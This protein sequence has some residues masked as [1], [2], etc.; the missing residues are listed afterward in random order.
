MRLRW[1]SVVTVLLLAACAPG[2]EE[3]AAPSVRTQPQPVLEPVETDAEDRSKRRARRFA[4]G[5]HGITTK[6]PKL[7]VYNRPQ[8]LSPWHKLDTTNP[9]DQ[10]L[11]LLVTEARATDEGL[12]LEVLLP[13]RPN[14]STAWVEKNQVRVVKLRHRI[15]I[16]LAR[17][18]LEHFRAGKRVQRFKVGVGEDQYPT[19]KGTYYVW[20]K[21]PQPSPAGPYG[22]YALGISGFSPVLSDWPGGGR[23]A[24]HGTANPGD[25]GRKV[26]HGCVRVFNDDM[27]KLTGVP[28]GTPVVI[29]S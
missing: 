13:E 16:D 27:R 9:L 18:T 15:E 17:Y 7:K 23:A 2:G 19:P 6:A 29:K 14:G 8:H 10:R 26:S 5:A 25:R 11:V 12:W 4:D 20:A 21:V 22:N 24:V 1:L 28:M 3:R